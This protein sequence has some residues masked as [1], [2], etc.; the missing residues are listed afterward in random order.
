MFPN[1]SKIFFLFL[2]IC[3]SYSQ[4][5]TQINCILP[6]CFCASKN[7]PGGLKLSDTPQFIFFTLDDSIVKSQLQSLN[8]LDFILRKIQFRDALGC[9]PKLSFYVRQLGIKKI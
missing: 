4:T 3:I 9:N 5:C 1:L 7:I 2:F 6:N 8:E